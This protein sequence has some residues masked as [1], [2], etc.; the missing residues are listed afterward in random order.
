MGQ[1]GWKVKVTMTANQI[2][3][4]VNAQIWTREFCQTFRELYP[5]VDIDEGWILSWFAN[6][7]MAG[8]DEGCRRTAKEVIEMHR[9]ELIMEAKIYAQHEIERLNNEKE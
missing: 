6:S 5:G 3:N 8:Y 9:S 4:T 1:R 7:I 2:P